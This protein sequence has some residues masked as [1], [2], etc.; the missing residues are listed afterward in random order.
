MKR[1]YKI[2]IMS[3]I[4]FLGFFTLNYYIFLRIAFL[5][6]FNQRELILSL[7]I[8]ASVSYPIAMFIERN[9]SNI[10]TRILYTFSSIWMGIAFFLLF[11]LI[12]YDILNI[13]L[14]LPSFISGITIIVFSSLLTFYSLLNSLIIHKKRFEI[15]FPSINSDIN[16]VQLS[17][18]HIGSIRNSGYM[19][20]VVKKTNELNP[21]IVLITG[22]LVDG[23]ARLHKKTFKAL[24]KIKCPVL[25]VIGNHEVYEGLNE[26][27]RILNPTKVKIL[28][29]DI[30]KFKGIQ[31]IGVDYSFKKNNLKDVL[32]SLEIEKNMPSILMYHVPQGL[33]VANEFGINLQIS[34]HT[35]SGQIIP[36]NILVKVLFPYFNGLYKF[37]DSYLYVS[38]GTGTWGP[39]MRLGSSNEITLIVLK[40]I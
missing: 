22:D 6:G 36:F 7:I 9:L 10:Y 8:I 4:F 40:P 15:P 25:F 5:L 31:I 38:A 17:D 3:V 34:G 18:I 23:S 39:P 32:S 1:I 2:L 33:K 19:E 30:F 28:R 29:N 37:N 26:V 35:H 14:I 16:V 20:K 13:I 24:D 12:V 11:L 21:D 27:Y